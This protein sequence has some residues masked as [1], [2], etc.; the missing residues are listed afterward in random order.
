ML[1]KNKLKGLI[2]PFKGR[3]K[4]DK[5]LL[6]VVIIGVSGMLL[7]L[8]SELM[9][10]DNETD[11]DSDTYASTAEA[12]DYKNEVT[13][14]LT[15]VISKISGVGEVNIMVMVDGTT[16]YVYAEDVDSSSDSDDASSSEDYSGKTVIV[17]ENGEK[18]PLLKK[19]V[20]PS[21][22]GVLVVCSG[23]DS[24][25]VIDKV[26]RAVS[27]ALNISRSSVCVVKG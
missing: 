17:E 16:E 20:Q 9:G 4:L 14:E 27:C 22:T 11:S 18:K 6:L 25:D 10:Q 21:V 1:L 7:I 13:K 12:D 8:L 26:S 24:Y 19:I 2:R 5:K 3:K 15:E 23:G